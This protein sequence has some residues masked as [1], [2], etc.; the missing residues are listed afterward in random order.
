M[1][2]GIDYASDAPL[3]LLS[4]GIDFF[5]SCFYGSC[6]DGVGIGD[7]QDDSDGDATERFGAEVVVLGRFV[8]EPEFGAVD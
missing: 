1:A 8:A 3:V 2:E 7:G 4:D 6:E 5:G